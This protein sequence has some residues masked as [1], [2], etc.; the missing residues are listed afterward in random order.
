MPQIKAQ[1]LVVW[2]KEDKL[3]PVA[4]APYITGLVPGAISTII[5]KASH[6]PQVDQPNALIAA[7]QSFF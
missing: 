4:L 1:T 5:E 3:F 2:G 7:V 6:F